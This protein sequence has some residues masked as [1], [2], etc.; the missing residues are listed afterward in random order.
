MLVTI[1][2]TVFA[3]VVLSKSVIVVPS[4]EAWILERL[5]RYDRTLPPGLHVICLS[6]IASRFATQSS[7]KTKRSPISA[8]RATMFRCA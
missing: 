5:G 2:L 8:S 6:R 1:V 7:R 3:V 4:G